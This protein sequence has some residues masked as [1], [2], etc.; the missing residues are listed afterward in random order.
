MSAHGDD[1]KV[2]AIKDQQFVCTAG[3]DAKC[4]TVPTCRDCEEW[5]G[6]SVT[7]E[8]HDAGEHCCRSTTQPGQPCWIEPWINA[9]DLED[10]F[11]GDALAAMVEDADGDLTWPDGPVTVEWQVDFCSWTYA[12]PVGLRA[13]T[14]IRGAH[15]HLS[16]YS[17]LPGDLL[18]K[19]A[20][21]T[22]MKEAPGLA[23]G[24]FVL[25]P[26]QMAAM[27]PV[28]FERHGLAYAIEVTS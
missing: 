19:E 24:G 25:T 3:P 23:V 15:P 8:Q 28:T 6:C 21:G 20:E 4:R 10:A 13:T 5:C 18:V 17:I 16:D 12:A 9:S 2:H 7:G 11:G 1:P 26:E 14:E 27:Q 22:Y